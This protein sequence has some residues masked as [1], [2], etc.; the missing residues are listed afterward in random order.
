MRFFAAIRMGAVAV[1]LL[2]RPLVPATGD[3]VGVS[4]PLAD[5][6]SLHV[7]LALLLVP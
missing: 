4:A 7:L 2:L 5:A 6:A 1:E 3:A